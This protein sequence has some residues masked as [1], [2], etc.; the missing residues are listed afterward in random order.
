MNASD[1]A[2]GFGAQVWSWTAR[3][4]SPD[5]AQ[6]QCLGYLGRDVTVML[7]VVRGAQRGRPGTAEQDFRYPL[8]GTVR[9]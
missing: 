2:P 3:V 1:G 5:S 4:S 9:R 7:I 8:A 6:I